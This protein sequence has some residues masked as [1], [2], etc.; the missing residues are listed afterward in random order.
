MCIILYILCSVFFPCLIECIKTLEYKWF[1]EKH[2][3]L[4][5]DVYKSCHDHVSQ[6]TPSFVDYKN[7]AWQPTVDRF[8]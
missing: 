4:Y 3:A 7:S 2:S 6:Y 1:R 8:S 5:K